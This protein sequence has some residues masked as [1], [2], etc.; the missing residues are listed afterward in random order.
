MPWRGVGVCHHGDEQDGYA[1]RPGIV[2]VR[3]SARVSV[4]ANGGR[5]WAALRV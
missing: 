5:S 3:I 1:D 4:G 2:V